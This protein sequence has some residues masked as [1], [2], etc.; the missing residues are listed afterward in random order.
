MYQSPSLV[1]TRGRTAASSTGAVK[2]YDFDDDEV[3][4]LVASPFI[5]LVVATPPARQP[6]L[7]ELR[8]HFLPEVIKTLEDL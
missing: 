4:G 1:V 5:D 2:R 8:P 7:I 6:S 3:D